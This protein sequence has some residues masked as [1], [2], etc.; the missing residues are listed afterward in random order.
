MHI[1]KNCQARAYRFYHRVN[2]YMEVLKKKS[3]RKNTV[4][5]STIFSYTRARA[6]LVATQFSR[7]LYLN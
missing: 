3:L 1:G 2:G 5:I 4:D 6:N 7:N